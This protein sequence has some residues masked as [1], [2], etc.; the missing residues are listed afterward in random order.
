[1]KAEDVIPLSAAAKKQIGAR[2]R[3]MRRSR[4]FTLAEMAE[5]LHM[6]EETLRRMEEGDFELY[7]DMSEAV[8][9]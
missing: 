4:N 8:I 9:Q 5:L 7:D 6:P 1:M 2:I 3:F